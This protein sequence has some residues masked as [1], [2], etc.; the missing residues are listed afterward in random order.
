[1]KVPD[2]VVL[3]VL[4]A[5]DRSNARRSIVRFEPDGSSSGAA[6]RVS[7]DGFGYEIRVNWF[8][9]GVTILDL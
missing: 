3:D 8:T 1:V 2:D 4:G 9:G 5:A 7:R 6:L